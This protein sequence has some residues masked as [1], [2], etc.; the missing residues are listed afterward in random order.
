MEDS[1]TSLHGPS[2]V[3][4]VIHHDLPSLVPSFHTHDTYMLEVG[5]K[6]AVIKR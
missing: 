1:D 2:T 3:R 6:T 4:N 5:S